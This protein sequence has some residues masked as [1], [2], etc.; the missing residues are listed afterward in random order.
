M[1]EAGFSGER[2]RAEDGERVGGGGADRGVSVPVLGMQ[3][4][5]DRAGRTHQDVYQ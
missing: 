2:D 5:K 3:G 4:D 1:Q